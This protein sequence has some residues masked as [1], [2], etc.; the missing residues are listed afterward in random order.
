MRNAARTLAAVA[1]LAFLATRSHA[2]LNASE[3]A[4]VSQTVD[5]TRI[6]V[7]YSR[8]RARGRTGL[9]GTQVP[10]G[11]VWT[12]GANQSTTI[13]IS[14]DVTIDGHAVA[15]GKYSV[16]IVIAKGDWEMVL[17]ADTTLFHTQGPKPRAGQ[18]RWIVKK[19]HRPFLE[20]LTWEFP[21]V[22]S[23]GMTLSMQWDTVAVSLAI[24]VPPSY[25]TAVAPDVA[26]RLVGTYRWQWAPM[27][28]PK[29]TTV[30]AEPALSDFD[31]IVTYEK[32]ELHALASPAMFGDENYARYLLIQKKGGWFA[33]GRLI[34]GELAEIWDFEQL[35]FTP[36]K[37]GVTG[38]EVRMKDDMLIANGTRKR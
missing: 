27:P 5:G 3:P 29:D 30:T 11:E 9:F 20:T 26:S 35:Q 13:A 18:V 10:W 15:K 36:T 24:K 2:Q 38:F 6:T 12:G 31:L 21:A 33:V 25:T 4:S 34:S 7:E 23:T 8:P 17:D 28:P 19:E 16:W 1:A 32:G 14:N 37:G 22:S